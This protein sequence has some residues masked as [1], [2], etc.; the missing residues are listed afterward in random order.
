M[1]RLDRVCND[2]L[3]VGV[4]N[5]VTLAISA[6]SA[7]A[8]VIVH[9][10]VSPGLHPSQ[11]R[12]DLHLPAAIEYTVTP[13]AR[14]EV[15]LGPAVVRVTGPWG[16]GWRQTTIDSQGKVRVDPNLAAIDV[17]EA[18]ARR[19]QLAEIGLRTMRLRTEGSEFERVRDAFPDDPLRAIN[20][21]ATARTG[22]LMA[23]RAHPGTRPAAG[24]LPRSRPSDGNRRR[25]AHQARPRDQRRIVTRAC[26]IAQRGSRRDARVLGHRHRNAAA[27]RRHGPTPSFPGC[28]APDPA[29][30]D[31]GRLR[32]RAG[33]LQQ[34]ADGAAPSWSSSPTCWT[35]TRG[36]R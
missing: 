29:G 31:R 22:R 11:S 12:W 26:R 13:V 24:G 21:R 35:P 17:Y 30:R 6:G 1:L 15:T 7:G 14:G 5:R 8:P 4:A 36:R 28:D 34:V 27:A 2:L 32:R 10:R 9:E 18:L 25:R 20:W 3:S 19:G 33:V 16:L 23:T